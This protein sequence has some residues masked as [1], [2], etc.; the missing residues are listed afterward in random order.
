[1]PNQPKTPQR[2]I[3]LDDEL[4]DGL[5]ES[6]DRTAVIRDLVRWYLGLPGARRPR[7]PDRSAETD[8]GKAVSPWQA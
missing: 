8:A 6:G 1:M 3:R 4:W 7:R 2:A 5:G